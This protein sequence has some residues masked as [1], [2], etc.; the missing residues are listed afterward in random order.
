VESTR[1][2]A[3]YARSK[4]ITLALEPL[5]RFESF[6]I[7]NLNIAKQFIEEVDAPN[8]K[9]HLDT[10]HMSIEE[11]NLAEVV[12]QAGE[13]L[14]NIHVSDSNRETPGRGHTDFQAIMKNLE[15]ISYRGYLVLEPVPPGSNP[16]FDA[17]R[18]SNFFLRDEY[19]KEG[20]EFL[21]NLE[22]TSG[23]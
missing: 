6:L 21:R 22:N 7:T 20:I 10:F 18:P 9:V 23:I 13:M 5:N 3:G 15:K 8:L 16:V 17:T 12:L 11:K 14:V 1:E 19:A 4:S 2:L